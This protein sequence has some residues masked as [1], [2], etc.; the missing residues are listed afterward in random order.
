[1]SRGHFKCQPVLGPGLF[2][3]LGCYVGRGGG[4][5][6]EE[7]G[8]I[9][10]REKL[11][12]KASHSSQRLETVLLLKL[13]RANSSI[14]P[15]QVEDKKEIDLLAFPC[16]VPFWGVRGARLCPAVSGRVWPIPFPLLDKEI[17]S[18]Q[19]KKKR[20]PFPSLRRRR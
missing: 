9:W 20:F 4:R 5:K 2:F 14:L 16:S 12:F 13:G 17:S 1:M 15:Y 10:R 3:R 11:T 8:K 18:F 6:W 19:K 7:D